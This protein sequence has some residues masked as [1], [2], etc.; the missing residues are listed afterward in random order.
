MPISSSA[1]DLFEATL[2]CV[3]NPKKPLL[4]G[5]LELAEETKEHMHVALPYLPEIFEREGRKQCLSLSAFELAVACGNDD[6]LCLFLEKSPT[7][8]KNVSLEGL[9]QLATL[10]LGYTSPA[11]YDMSGHLLWNFSRVLVSRKPRLFEARMEHCLLLRPEAFNDAGDGI[12]IKTD[13]ERLVDTLD[14]HHGIEWKPQVFS[15]IEAQSRE[16]WSTGGKGMS[17]VLPSVLKRIPKEWFVKN[18]TYKEFEDRMREKQNISE[19]VWSIILKRKME[20]TILEKKKAQKKD[21]V[22]ERKL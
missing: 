12:K 3:N 2:D 8:L 1:Y 4:K 7:P 17:V 11:D 19:E 21:F 20:K 10:G 16:E 5:F 6:L 18:T 9:S 15:F 22:K 14:K 13:V